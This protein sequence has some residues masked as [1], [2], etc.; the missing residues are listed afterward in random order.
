MKR[1]ALLL[2][3][4]FTY[5][6]SHAQDEYL[7]GFI[8]KNQQD[9]IYGELKVNPPITY[10]NQ[11]EFRLNGDVS[12]YLPADIIGYKFSGGRFF[13]SKTII[14][15][16]E[17]KEYFLDYLID[18]VVDVYFLADK[19][20]RYFIDR[21]DGKLIELTSTEKEEYIDGTKYIRN[22]KEY[23]GI[24]KYVFAEDPKTSKNAESASLSQKSLISL[25]EDFH[26]A[27]CDE[28]QKCIVY[29]KSDFKS[30]FSFGPLVEN[31]MLFLNTKST[32][33]PS[34]FVFLTG[35]KL[36]SVFTPTVGLFLELNMSEDGYGKGSMVYEFSLSKVDIS[37]ESEV[38]QARDPYFYSLNI[39]F[40]SINNS[41]S[42]KHLVNTKVPIY[43][44][45]GLFFNAS[46]SFNHETTYISEPIT[47]PSNYQ[48]E[49]FRASDLGPM[50][51]VGAYKELAS[52]KR[53]MG[54]LKYQ[55]GF[56][57]T[58]QRTNLINSNYFIL[59]IKYT[60]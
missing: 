13:V 14:T 11:C 34:M 57:F 32:S 35:A 29:Q 22:K 53:I 50:I 26:Y 5:F 19:E 24:L 39:N 49:P 55:Y 3:L 51:G 1:K 17:K 41:L 60:L 30:N 8:I 48:F 20:E 52:R 10:S 27:V 9:T 16:N 42:Y 40:W 44:L 25:A 54:E 59:G 47:R 2:I 58:S 36:K 6:I 33:I 28:N 45:G 43:V 38:F 23:I 7:P 18:G 56:G 31:R 12:T 21:G 37:G 15:D 46:T 4:I